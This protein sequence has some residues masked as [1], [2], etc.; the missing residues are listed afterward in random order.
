MTIQNKVALESLRKYILLDGFDMVIDLEKSKGSWILDEKSGEKYLDFFSFFASAPVGF[1]H[2]DAVEDAEFQRHLRFAALNK[3]SNSGTVLEYAKYA[4]NEN[5]PSK[6]DPDDI[7]H[8]YFR[9]IRKK[10][11]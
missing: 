7:W 3:V 9:F 6:I 2:P 4:S 11:E 1:N 8:P 10:T 5:P